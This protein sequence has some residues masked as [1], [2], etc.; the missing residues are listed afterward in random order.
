MKRQHRRR[1]LLGA[2]LILLL[3][4]G[5]FWLSR[6]PPAQ[7]TE[8][9]VENVDVG[10]DPA[11]KQEEGTVRLE[12][13]RHLIIDA[14]TSTATALRNLATNKYNLRYEMWQKKKRLYKSEVITP[15]GAINTYTV[16][17]KAGTHDV[18]LRAVVVDPET[19]ASMNTLTIPVKLTIQ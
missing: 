6:E 4:V 5:G 17:L 1:W 16:A 9:Q 15:G 14:E 18:D 8:S 7:K 3:I 10:P 13:T 19:K 2:L 12:Q 11:L